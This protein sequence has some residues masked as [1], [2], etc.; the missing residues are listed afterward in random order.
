MRLKYMYDMQLTDCEE[1]T[2]ERKLI[3]LLS[4]LDLQ[5]PIEGGS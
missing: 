3:L 5:V 1:T 2:Y 4:A